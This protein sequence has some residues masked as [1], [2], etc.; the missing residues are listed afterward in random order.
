MGPIKYTY[1]C[2]GCKKI[3]Y[4]YREMRQRNYD[5]ICPMC[6]ES[7]EKII[8]PP[9]VLID[10]SQAGACP[11]AEMKWDTDRNK[12]RKKEEENVKEFGEGEEY[13]NL[14]TI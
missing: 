1:K 4:E 12:R 11:G 3:H 5:S 7:C 14:R 13:P 9:T 10:G 6:G 8:D 2:S